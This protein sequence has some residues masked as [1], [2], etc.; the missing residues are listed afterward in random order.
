VRWYVITGR[1]DGEWEDRIELVQAHSQKEAEDIFLLN[2][3]SATAEFSEMADAAYDHD[4]D[5]HPTLAQLRAHEDEHGGL[6][7]LIHTVD[8]GQPKPKI[9]RETA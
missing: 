2:L 8:C 7:H 4:E 5:L 3:W 6:I 9:L 1:L